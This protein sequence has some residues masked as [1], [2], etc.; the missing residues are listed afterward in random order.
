MSLQRG[1]YFLQWVMQKTTLVC[2]ASGQVGGHL[3]KLLETQ[4]LPWRALSR[5]APRPS[6][7]HGQWVQGDFE[8]P[9]TLAQTLAGVE[10]VF[11]AS[12]DH[13]KQDELELNM[14]RA[15]KAAN[16]EHVVKL[17]AQSASLS[18]A[19]SFGMFHRKVEQ[20]LENSQMHWTVLRPNFFIQSLAFFKDDIRK[21][22][23]IAPAGKG[24]VSLVDIRDVAES[25]FAVLSNPKPH[26]KRS[27]ILT[28]PQAV[29]FTQVC[30][31]L[32]AVN[33]KPVKH[34]SPPSAIAKVV[35]PFVSGMPRWQSNLAVDLMK[36]IANGAQSPV[37]D[38]VMQLTGHQP[39]RI[40][41]YLAESAALF[42]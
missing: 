3:V 35:L 25:A 20:A 6:G 17:S 34:I 42:R 29:S 22:R 11:L 12:A 4:G 19:V 32:S 5:S 24:K 7:K 31:Q 9:E 38:G 27:Y 26:I 13:P 18:P 8:K 30:E 21:G 1:V 41:D 39:R 40:E 33:G 15:C 10:Q 14:L 37:S 36:A 23:L 28:G 2:G 16:V